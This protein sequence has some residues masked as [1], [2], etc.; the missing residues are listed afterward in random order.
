M[1]QEENWK[2]AADDMQRAI[3]VLAPHRDQQGTEAERADVLKRDIRNKIEFA[4]LAQRW[5][6]VPCTELLEECQEE[7]K[8][9]ASLCYTETDRMEQ[10]AF[11]CEILAY[12]SK[13][14]Q[15]KGHY[16]LEKAKQ[17]AKEALDCS[18]TLIQEAPTTDNLWFHMYVLDFY[19]TGHYKPGGRYPYVEK[20]LQAARKIYAGHPSLEWKRQLAW[21]TAYYAYYADTAIERRVSLA[22]DDPSALLKKAE[23]AWKEAFRLYEE[24]L[25]EGEYMDSYLNDLSYKAEFDQ[26]RG[27]LK[28][29]LRYALRG[30]E[31]I[32]AG[33]VSKEYVQWNIRHI[34]TLNQAAAFSCYE[35]SRPQ[36]ALPYARK[37]AELARE[38]YD[39]KGKMVYWIANSQLLLAKV[40][41]QLRHDEEALSGCD[42]AQG[43]FEKMEKQDLGS[44]RSGYA[45]I[46]YIRGRLA[47]E[48][49]DI[50]AASEYERKYAELT[51]G[52]PDQSD[53]QIES[54]WRRGKLLMLQAD[55]RTALNEKEKA[56]RLYY[57][58]IEIWHRAGNFY[59]GSAVNP[60]FL[61]YSV[62]EVKGRLQRNKCYAD[63]SRQERAYYY[64]RYCLYHYAEASG[65]WE[66]VEK[67]HKPDVE[68]G[69]KWTSWIL[70]PYI[71]S[72]FARLDA[73]FQ[74]E[75][76]SISWWRTAPAKRVE[77]EP[78]PLRAASPG[79]FLDKLEYYLSLD[80]KDRMNYALM[81]VSKNEPGILSWEIDGAYAER[82]EKL[83]E[84]LYAEIRRVIW[85]D[86]RIRTVVYSIARVWHLSKE[87]MDQVLAAS[88]AD[89]DILWSKEDI[90]KT[91]WRPVVLFCM[92]AAR[93]GSRF[94]K[95]LLENMI[96][97]ESDLLSYD[98]QKREGDWWIGKKDEEE[99][100]S[101]DRWRLAEQSDVVLDYLFSVKPLV[102][103]KENS[104]DLMNIVAVECYRRKGDKAIIW[105]QLE[106]IRETAEKRMEEDA[107]EAYNLHYGSK[108]NRPPFDKTEFIGDGSWKI[109]AECVWK[110]Y[111]RLIRLDGAY[112]F[113]EYLRFM[114][115]NPLMF[116]ALTGHTQKT[117]KKELEPYYNLIME[118]G[119]LLGE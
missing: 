16:D 119:T 77:C 50:A 92:L 5:R 3:E 10:K 40:L 113:R 38:E 43:Y 4:S 54:K 112:W 11:Q 95:K 6:S 114:D 32:D 62:E 89:R 84:T 7:L 45:D 31:I 79:H 88:G 81:F 87:K 55:I 25:E 36:E 64:E 105:E 118:D 115:A 24:L 1:Y 37:A 75:L 117:I 27:Y 78:E 59:G 18:E 107:R 68:H 61:T 22:P 111:R 21:T 51:D 56:A 109:M 63:S 67:S 71:R 69:Y 53:E 104:W 34:F 46:A 23:K 44:V 108:K 29:A 91:M 102:P 57:E 47:L 42:F 28:N 19:A 94:S 101:T 93:G 35:M 70:S 9:Y 103:Q 76:Q 97:A 82:F 110:L 73:G 8:E 33:Q 90:M 65:D 26:K 116:K 85:D 2:L 39:Q 13:G 74:S 52:L 30:L 17:Y 20:Q 60:Y 12:L 99:K 100:T 83:T 15:F 96:W 58:A 66:Y 72:S 98:Q 41:Y 14:W 86:A 80:G 48:K 49:G 106:C